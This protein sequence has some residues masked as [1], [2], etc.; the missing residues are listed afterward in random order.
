MSPRIAENFY[1]QIG[2]E[3]GWLGLALL[4][5]VQAWVFRSLWAV[6]RMMLP[7]ILLASGIGLTIVN[8]FSHAWA[9]DTLGLL[10]W[11]MAG[12]AISMTIRDNTGDTDTI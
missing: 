12:I 4:V 8:L 10:W 9:D 7:R 2:Q 5:A 6:R 1:L 11:G 3:M